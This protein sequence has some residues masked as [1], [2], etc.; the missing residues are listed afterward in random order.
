MQALNGYFTLTSS[1]LIGIPQNLGYMGA[2]ALIGG[3][4]AYAVHDIARRVLIPFTGD[5][6]IMHDP[7]VAAA[8]SMTSA[9]AGFTA[10]YLL[11]PQAVMTSFTVGKV[12][13]LALLITPL[14]LA[15]MKLQNREMGM[16]SLGVAG[17]VA[18]SIIGGLLGTA[19]P[20]IAG[21]LAGAL[22]SLGKTPTNF[23]NPENERRNS[24][25]PEDNH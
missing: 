13:Q 10:T 2:G 9:L 14:F 20:S 11:A 18:L 3:I 25:Y 23:K 5:D 22:V 7:R 17:V 1:D 19:A 12:I 16:F 4:T 8:V 15:A 6:R 21:G 24:D